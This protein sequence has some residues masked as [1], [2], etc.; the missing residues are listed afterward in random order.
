MATLDQ[1]AYNI[2]NIGRAGLGNSDDERLGIRQ[3]KF[4]IQGYRAEGIE[5]VTDFGKDIDPQL[6][7]DFGIFPLEEVDKSDTNCPPEIDWGCTIKKFTI[8]KLVSLPLNRALMFVGKIDK[9]T[10]FVRDNANVHEWVKD[11]RFGPLFNR[12]YLI[13]NT[14][15]VELNK[16]DANMKYAHAR[17]VAEDP[18]KVDKFELNNQGECVK[19]CYD[20]AVDEYPLTMKLYRFVTSNILQIELGL[21]LQTVEDLLNNAQNEIQVTRPQG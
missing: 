11:T 19:I 6:V 7:T 13:G 14:V 5:Q 8:P 15:Y 17:G 21:T 1:W 4:W 20:D 18:T 3:I 2:R 16:K 9:Q 10:S 12:Y